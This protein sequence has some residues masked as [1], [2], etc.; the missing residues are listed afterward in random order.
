MFGISNSSLYHFW[1]FYVGFIQCFISS[2]SYGDKMA[3]ASIAKRKFQRKRL[4][5]RLIQLILLCTYKGLYWMKTSHKS[6]EN[7]ITNASFK[8]P[9]PRFTTASRGRERT[10]A[11]A[12]A[13]VVEGF[14]SRSSCHVDV[15]Y[16][17]FRDLMIYLRIDNLVVDLR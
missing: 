4:E 14:R 13:V 11:V 9:R 10:V 8:W 7:I 16:T 6:A 3:S 1:H 17:L 2:H 15:H 5:S 12:V